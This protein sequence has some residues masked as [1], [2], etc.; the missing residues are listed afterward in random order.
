VAIFQPVT[1]KV[2]TQSILTVME[3]RLG[4]V[5]AS[6]A[7]AARTPVSSTRIAERNILYFLLW[8]ISMPQAVSTPDA[9]EPQLRGR[10]PD[11]RREVESLLAR[12]SSQPGAWE[13][14]VWDGGATEL[15]T[16]HSTAAMVTPGTQLGPYKIQGPLG[17]GGMGEVYK[18]HD[19][20]LGRDIAIKTLPYEFARDPD[21]LARF[22]RE[23]RVL[24]SLNHPNIA[25]I[26][27]LEESGG[28]YFLVMEFCPRSDTGGAVG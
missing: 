3:D 13:R 9:Q 4:L 22:R 20:K 24:A 17:K 27:R 28:S 11:V 14:P 26:H 2:P 19:T 12:D 10:S 7:L 15:M 5:C 25:T 21:R 16:A 1:L 23:V 8:E 18:A 6:P